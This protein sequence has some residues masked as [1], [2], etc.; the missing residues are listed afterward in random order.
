MKKVSK[1][2]F[3]KL[4]QRRKRLLYGVIG[5]I[6]DFGSGGDGSNPSRESRL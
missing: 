4:I 5:S 3:S 2:S 6:P 1:G